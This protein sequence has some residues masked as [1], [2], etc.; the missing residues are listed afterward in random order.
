MTDIIN[1]GVTSAKRQTWRYGSRE[2][3]RRIVKANPAKS[4]PP[5]KSDEAKWRRLYREQIRDDEDLVLA[6]IDYCFVA[7]LRALLNGRPAR[8]AAARNKVEIEAG[9]QRL[10][11]K[12]K[13]LVL[14]D[15]MMPNGKALG[16]CTGE[17][18]EQLH[19]WA[20]QLA[21]LVPAK[22]MVADVLSEKD[23]RKLWRASA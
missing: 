3:L 18:C 1:E 17:E 16:R 14:L 5:S 10:A 11:P 22:K 20:K 23:V 4:V 15:L 6:A 2:V 13:E 7:D 8:E 19:G 12:L 9:A 21:K